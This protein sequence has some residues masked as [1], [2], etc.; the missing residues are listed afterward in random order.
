MELWEA[1]MSA[2][3]LFGPCRG[4]WSV[5]KVRAFANAFE[6]LWEEGG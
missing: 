6:V 5:K 1:N 3:D 4:Q 2:T